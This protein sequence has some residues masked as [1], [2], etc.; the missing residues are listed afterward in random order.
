MVEE[1]GKVIITDVFEKF[2]DLIRISSFVINNN[3]PARGLAKRLGFKFEGTLEDSIVQ[4]GEPRPASHF[5]LTKKNWIALCQSQ[6]L[7][8]SSQ[9]AL[10]PQQAPS[11][12][13]VNKVRL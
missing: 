9:A 11:E 8:L 4:S 10:E 6:R 7:S 13:Q 1:A 2:P 12:D 5:G 3:F